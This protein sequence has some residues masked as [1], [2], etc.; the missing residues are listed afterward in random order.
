[1]NR[2]E[3]DPHEWLQETQEESIH[4]NFA[5]LGE[6]SEGQRGN[7]VEEIISRIEARQIDITSAYNDWRDIGFALSTEFGESGR[8]YF[9]RISRYY[10]NYSVSECDVQYDKCMKSTGSGVTL[11]TFFRLAKSAGI[12]IAVE[13]QEL[14]NEE[15]LPYFP[16][17]VYENLPEFLTAL[18][19]ISDSPDDKDLILI[20]SIVTLSSAIPNVYGL[21]HN[22]KVFSNLYLFVSAQ[23]S[24]GKGILTHCAHL[25]DPI[26]RKMR[27][28]SM[29]LK[30]DYERE[31]NEYLIIRKKN[32][33][34]EKPQRP[35]EK[36]LFIPA[37]SSAAGVLQLLY[38]NDGRG[39]IF[40]T[41]GDTMAY[42]F[43]SDYGNYS[44]AFRKAFHHETIRYYR[45][46]DREFVDLDKP[47]LSA[48]LSGTPKQI[49]NLIP[50]VEN[51]LFSRFIFYALQITSEWKDVFERK[52][53]NGYDAFFA[54]HGEKFY[55]LYHQL[56]GMVGV[57]FT[58]TSGQQNQF[59]TVFS[60]WQTMYDTLLGAEYIGTV[61][62]LGLI[63]FRIALI[64]SVLRVL[65]TGDLQ[66]LLICEESDFQ[67]AIS[68]TEVLILHAKKVFSE[69][70]QSA[71][72]VKRE[73]REERF[74]NSLNET[75]TRKDYVEAAEKL[76][77]PD[78]TA[79]NYISKYLNKGLIHRDKQGLYL[80]IKR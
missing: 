8:A 76:Q 28:E 1:M 20:G 72:V 6:M 80:K 18:C 16:A 45:K 70:P 65:E 12:N 38:D 17:S 44:D 4:E 79:Q 61:R 22:R 71:P 59:N 67:N 29:R 77:I 57:E 33:A 43:K 64:F 19:N 75:F 66:S 41:E 37:N 78:K 36:M 32:P 40:E 69:L 62:R 31:F 14:K 15:L 11:K 26:Q 68:I 35:P 46:T 7:E 63:T 55:Q 5:P 3:F 58:L 47:C 10:P 50:D 24:A 21:Y 2:K 27:E 56:N 49:Q 42:T 39:L 73:N 51:G 48:V 30:A 13:P 60:H 25:V 23:A 34:A 74:Y 52:V 53:E 9:H 54:G